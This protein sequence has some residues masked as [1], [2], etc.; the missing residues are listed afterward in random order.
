[1]ANVRFAR[2]CLVAL[3]LATQASALCNGTV[4]WPPGQQTV[5]TLSRPEGDRYY[6]VYIPT[7]YQANTATGLQLLFHG[8]NDNCYNFINATGFIPFAEA[9]GYIVVAPCATIGLLGIAWNSGTCCGFIDDQTPNDLEFA[10]KV[11]E[12]VSSKLCIDKN[13]VITSGFSNGAMMTQVLG[14]E[15]PDIFRGLASVSG[16]VELRPGNGQG[17]ARCSNNI[18]KSTKRPSLLMIHGDFD[19]LVPWTGDELLGFPTVPD[20][21][22]GW[23]SRNSC[24]GNWTQTLNIKDYTNQV[25]TN[26]KGWGTSSGSVELVRHHGGGHEWPEDQFDATGYIHNWTMRLWKS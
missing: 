21:L 15:S 22:Q 17:I 4:P 16:I 19:F 8:L 20:N 1:M 25:W 18:T 13:K 6:I 2:L 9:E 3:L 11:V 26:C 23:L 12:S 5:V 24:V 10:R 7:T 14:C